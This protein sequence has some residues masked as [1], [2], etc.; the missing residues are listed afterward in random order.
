MV[1]S[2]QNHFAE[3]ELANN[4]LYNGKEMQNDELANIKLGWYDYG[5]RMYDAEL[6][7]WHV[8]HNKAEKYSA[9]SP[10]TYALNN[11]IPPLARTYSPCCF[12]KQGSC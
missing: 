7:R 10:Y 3:S 5:A 4:Y 8:I 11:P 9:T 6:G 2:Q 1:M 12:Q